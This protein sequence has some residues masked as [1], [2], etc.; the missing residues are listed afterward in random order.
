LI[1]VYNISQNDLNPVY[2]YLSIRSNI[3]GIAFFPG[4]PNNA[5]IT[6]A[7]CCIQVLNVNSTTSLS[8]SHILNVTQDI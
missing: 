8:L 4:N 1:R 6:S 2:E 5:L 7:S 3:A